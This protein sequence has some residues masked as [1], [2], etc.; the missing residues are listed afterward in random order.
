M[1]K[2][3][4]DTSLHVESSNFYDKIV[5]YVYSV[6]SKSVCIRFQGLHICVRDPSNREKMWKSKPLPCVTERDIFAALELEYK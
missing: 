3:V 1:L 6:Y 5:L 2:F 4:E